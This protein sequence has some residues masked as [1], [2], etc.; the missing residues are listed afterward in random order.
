MSGLRAASTYSIISG[1]SWMLASGGLDGSV[2]FGVAVSAA[3]GGRV[4]CVDRVERE[5]VRFLLEVRRVV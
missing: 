1:G 3:L 2:V 5:S 4:V